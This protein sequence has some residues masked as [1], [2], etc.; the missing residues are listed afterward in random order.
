MVIDQRNLIWK[1]AIVNLHTFVTLVH[2]A[3]LHI[4]GDFICMHG[5]WVEAQSILRVN[6]RSTQIICGRTIASGVG[7]GRKSAK[8]HLCSYSDSRWERQPNWQFHLKF[9]FRRLWNAAMHSCHKAVNNY[10]LAITY[11]LITQSSSFNR[12]IP[13]HASG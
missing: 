7:S 6:W 13:S 5:L 4:G 2:A 12:R 10:Q 11:G 8:L 1:S 9:V 3:W